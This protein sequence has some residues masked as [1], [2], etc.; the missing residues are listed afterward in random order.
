MSKAPVILHFVHWPVSGIIALLRA[1]LANSDMRR[2][3]H[4][5]LLCEGD[6]EHLKVFDG[7]IA[8]GAI[9]SATGNGLTIA[10]QL[11]TYLRRWQ[12]DLV[13]SHSF[14]PSF[15]TALLRQQHLPHLRTI[16][17]CYPY[18][19]QQ[20]I[21]SRIK[22]A[23]ERWALARSN[24]R[25]VAVS[26]E[27]SAWFAEVYGLPVTTLVNGVDGE[28]IKL[29]AAGDNAGEALVIEKTAGQ[30]VA[31]SCGRLHSQK[32]FDIA[33]S[34][35]TGL[36][37]RFPQLV[38][39]IIGEG[40][41]RAALAAQISELGLSDKVKLLGHQCNPY[42]LLA[43]SDIYLAASRYEGFGLAT[44]E[45]MTLGLPVVA[46]PGAVSPLKL[47][48][49]VAVCLESLTVDALAAGVAEL[50]DNNERRWQLAEQAKRFAQGYSIEDTA[51]AYVQHYSAMLPSQ[52]TTSGS[53]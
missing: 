3:R 50:V 8:E 5:L 33:V 15:W 12:P 42:A 47:N 51:S 24:T 46:A 23:L 48:H 1:L 36:S 4:Y 27:A 45:A 37:K 9:L 28:A 30:V 53:I 2:Y 14:Q 44:L 34:A 13:H 7:L 39:W 25:T 19:K 18:F 17:N 10:R 32:G 26:A 35:M 21:G 29:A 43:Q 6:A 11:P 52:L 16:H 31:V 22:R 40:E 49:T 41:Q 20:S 38:L